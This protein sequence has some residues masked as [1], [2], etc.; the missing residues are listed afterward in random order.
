MN[1]SYLVF[2]V[3]SFANNSLGTLKGLFSSEEK[4]Q[5]YISLQPNPSQFK[6]EEWGVR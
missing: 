4:A 3:L 6:I 2:V 5:K 1:Q